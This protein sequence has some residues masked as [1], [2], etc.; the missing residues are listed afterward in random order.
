[1][2]H[3]ESN[4]GNALSFYPEARRKELEKK[5]YTNLILTT[6]HTKKDAVIDA[7]IFGMSDSKLKEKALAGDLN[8]D[9]LVKW[10]QAR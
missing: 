8:M 7:T 3:S 9:T 5:A 10:G 1:M 2:A 6:T 4:N